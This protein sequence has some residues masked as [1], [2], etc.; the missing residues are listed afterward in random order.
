MLT[1]GHALFLVGTLTQRTRPH[2]VRQPRLER[3]VWDWV[4]D[5]DC[6]L[7]REAAAPAGVVRIRL[8][9]WPRSVARGTRW[10]YG[11]CEGKVGLCATPETYGESVQMEA[12]V[13]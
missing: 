2:D 6:R 9:P 10:C 8:L 4:C 1:S 5:A 12:S 7:S 13:R 11:V 3:T